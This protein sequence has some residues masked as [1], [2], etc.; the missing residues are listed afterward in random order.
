MAAPAFN[1]NPS[2]VYL[3]QIKLTNFRNYETLNL[4]L[5]QRHVVLTGENGSGKTNLLEAVSFLSPGRGLRRAA[6]DNVGRSGS[7]GAWTVFCEL[8][9]PQG[10]MSV[11]TGLTQS[12]MGL[13][14]QR[15]IRI[16]GTQVKIADE[17]LDHSRIIWL[18]PLMD[19]LFVGPAT[20]RRK[21]LDRL[22]L[23]IN[24]A[25]GRHVAS[26]EKAMRGRNKLLND[27]TND[28]NWLD[29]IEAQMAELGTAIAAARVEL[30]SLLSNEIVHNNDPNSPFPDAMLTLEGVLESAQNDM[31]SSDLEKEYADRLR[32][33]RWVDKGA[34]RT[35]EG[36]HRSDLKVSHGPKSMAAKLCSTGEQKAL[37]V[38]IILAHANL[39]SQ[40]NGF[41]PILLLD[42]ITA[43][44][45]EARRAALFDL[46]DR[47]GCQSFMTGT[48]QQLFNSLGERGN[49]LT[50]ADGDVIRT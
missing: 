19:G 28:M 16:N 7:S 10:C 38:G 15:K 5:D 24:P 46:I 31:P 50:V 23:A 8:N 12:A 1:T 20:E 49:Y 21:F 3:S 40:I 41:P 35:L 37:L 2:K 18:T 22:V 26:F 42:E 39:T 27:D 47:L 33:S 36:P 48:D 4:N 44:L 25:H 13:E 30:V 17:L 9:G 29:A 11:G 6:Y 14:T 43:H 34:G 45:D 32:A